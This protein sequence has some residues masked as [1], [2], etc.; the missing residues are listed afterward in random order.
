MTLAQPAEGQC[1]HGLVQLTYHVQF[2]PRRGLTQQPNQHCFGLGA[3]VKKKRRR[4]RVRSAVPSI[5][6]SLIPVKEAC[7]EIRPLTILWPHHPL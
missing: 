2:A 1:P 3:S 4:F 6:H 7:S 5:I